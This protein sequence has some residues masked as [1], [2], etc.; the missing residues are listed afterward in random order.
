MACYIVSLIL[1]FVNIYLSIIKNFSN[2]S[3]L[4]TMMSMFAV[5]F[6]NE[7]LNREVMIDTQMSITTILLLAIRHP[8][9]TNELIDDFLKG[10]DNDENR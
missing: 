8:N 7:N 5:M 10:R 9:E 4:G 6:C 3:I 1:F 2:V